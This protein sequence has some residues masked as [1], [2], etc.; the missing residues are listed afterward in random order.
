MPDGDLFKALRRRTASI[1]TDRIETFTEPGI[2]LES[3]EELEADIVV[4]ATGLNL[5]AFGGLELVVDG[6]PVELPRHG[7]LQG[8]DAQRRAELRLRHRL[9]ELLLDAEGR[10]RLRVLLPAA[11]A[12]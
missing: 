9:H 7:R 8:H 3:G 5:L 11:R 1:V 4:T 10:P 12:T 6:E 2:Q